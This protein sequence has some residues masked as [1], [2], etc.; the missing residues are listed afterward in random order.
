MN[1]VPQLRPQ[2][3]LAIVGPTASGK[4]EI[5]M[6]VAEQVG[7]EIVAVDSMTIYRGMDIGTAKPT[8]VD[9]ERV[10]HHLLDIAD[11]AKPY[12]VAQFQRAARAAIAGIHARGSLPLLVG[13]SGLYFRAVVDDLQFPPTDPGVRERISTQDPHELRRALA[14]KD[15]IAHQRIEEGNIRRVIRALEVMELT[16]TPFSAFRASWDTYQSRYDVRIA[17]LRR[18]AEALSRR[19]AERTQTMLDAGLEDEVRVLLHQGLRDAL[20]A[21]RAIAYR[22]MVA[23]VDGVLNRS[24]AKSLIEAATRQYARRQMTWFRKDPRIQW[25]DPSNGTSDAVRK[26]LH[27]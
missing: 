1:A 17:G 6:T 23:V 15:P 2:P 16:G 4:S 19:I 13:G 18:D 20:T 3:V 26:A 27:V 14:A 11:P 7:A 25:V 22:E 9:R 12:S 5:A 21:S 10:P 24:E 8:A